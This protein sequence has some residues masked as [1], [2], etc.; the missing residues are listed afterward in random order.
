MAQQPLS[1]QSLSI[2]KM[3][4]LPKGLA[5]YQ[6]LSPR[7]NIIAGPNASGKSSTAQLIKKMLWP[8][9]LSGIEAHGSLL[10]GKENWDIFLDGNKVS[11]QHNGINDELKGLPNREAENRYM[12]ALHELIQTNEKDLA[13]IIMQESIG[14]YDLDAAKNE[15]KYESKPKSST[16]KE[17]KAFE[18]SKKRYEEA[19]D[20]QKT[21][22][23]EEEQLNELEKEKEKAIQAASYNEYYKLIADYKIAEKEASSIYEQFSLYPEVLGQMNGE[24]YTTVRDLNEEIEELRDVKR[25]TDHQINKSREEINALEIPEKGIPKEKLYELE[26][27]IRELEDIRKKLINL[28][29]NKADAVKQ[30]EIAL[31][32][33]NPS[34]QNPE[35][36]G[37]ELGQLNDLDQFIRDAH[38]VK[39]QMQNLQDRIEKLQQEYPQETHQ[40]KTKTERGIDYLTQWLKTTINSSNIHPKWLY[41]MSGA[42]LAAAITALV[43]QHWLLFMPAVI[44]S[45]IIIIDLVRK[46]QNTH[47]NISQW[48]DSYNHLNIGT[49]PEWTP[50][51]VQEKLEALIRQL[52]NLE[53]QEKISQQINT[54]R[55]NLEKVQKQYKQIEQIYESYKKKLHALPQLPETDINSYTGMAYFLENLKK[56]QLHHS[57]AQGFEEQIKETTNEGQKLLESINTI[58][59]EY[60]EK[61]VQ[62]AAKARAVFQKLDEKENKRQKLVLEI[63]QLETTLKDKNDSLQKKQEKLNN[64]YQKLKLKTD[65]Q[66]A[67]KNLV[68]QYETYHKLKNELSMARRKAKEK[69]DAMK[70]HPFFKKTEKGPETLTPNEAETLAAEYKGQSEKIITIREQIT[71]IQTKIN[72]AKRKHD[73]EYT[74]Q[75]KEETIQNLHERYQENLSGMTGDLLINKLK[76]ESKETNRPPVFHRANKLLGQITNGRYQLHMDEENDTA[77]TAYDTLSIK[78]QPLPLDQLSTGTRIQLLLSVRLAFIETQES[79]YKLPLLADELLANSDESRARAIIETLIEIS[80]E[81]RQVF[82]FTAQDDEVQKWEQYLAHSDINYQLINLSGLPAEKAYKHPGAAPAIKLSKTGLP[83]P[84]KNDHHSYGESLGIPPFNLLTDN[85]E[86]MHLWY[87]IDNTSLLHQILSRGIDHW[88]PLKNF[89]EQGGKIEGLEEKKIQNLYDITKILSEYIELYKQGRP[90]PIDRQVLNESG[91]ISPKFIDQVAD[92]LNQQNN[93]PLHLIEALKNGAISGFRTNK[94][95]ELAHFLEHDDYLPTTEPIKQEEIIARLQASLSNTSIAP[96]E[97]EELISRLNKR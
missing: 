39:S 80:K 95:D 46:N 3:P 6:E 16:I 69:E 71:S 79:S 62:D 54:H 77:F 87:L 73:L 12:L 64:I 20:I 72:E 96:S 70:A 4:G 41:I 52:N 83:D 9:D 14:G 81:G 45:V 55:E 19:L 28:K 8:G 13:R 36:Q 21:L 25:N 67:I 18:K 48:E 82:Y 68:D 59:G 90:K 74:L 94:A 29:Q 65:E 22:K 5:P 7:I 42:T 93:N 78:K 24:E 10:A 85:I 35:W 88:G 63:K 40:D 84:E 92:L 86:Q 60:D 26:E 34:L 61:T 32:A 76:E 33:I 56:W 51:Y 15:L 17:Y 57:A 50:E 30:K 1:F 27:N 66:Y 75:Q 38:H 31:S 58:A 47:D 49:I 11:S 2:N 89:L 91:A 43:I 37:I 44:F 53:L 23:K 97:I